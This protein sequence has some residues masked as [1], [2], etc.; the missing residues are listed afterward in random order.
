MALTD[1]RVEWKKADKIGE[2]VRY[3]GSKAH[4]ELQVGKYR[5]ADDFDKSLGKK[6]EW[7][8]KW[9]VDFMNNKKIKLFKSKQ[10]ALKFAK[11]YMRLH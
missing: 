7:H 11:S 2:T 10:Q 6:Y 8:N 5:G 1:W 9:Y 4:H 3:W